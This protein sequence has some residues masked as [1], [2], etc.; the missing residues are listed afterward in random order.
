MILSSSDSPTN[1]LLVPLLALGEILMA[2]RE[3][4]L[5]SRA[6]LPADTP[7]I[8]DSQYLGL[9]IFKLTAPSLH[10]PKPL[11]TPRTLRR[12]WEG[13]WCRVVSVATPTLD[14]PQQLTGHLLRCGRC[15]LDA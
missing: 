8:S 6:H 4:A 13:T 3:I 9:K 10:L 14:K 15:D 2:I 1:T 11:G 7:P 12:W 5:N